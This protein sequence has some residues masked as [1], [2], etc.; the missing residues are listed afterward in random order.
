MV[1]N[2]TN[3]IGDQLALH[4]GIQPV[5]P[6]A[7]VAGYGRAN[8]VDGSDQLGPA[9]PY[10][11]D[12]YQYDNVDAQID[13]W[14]NNPAQHNVDEPIDSE[15]VAWNDPNVVLEGDEAEDLPIMPDLEED[16]D[17]DD[18]PEDELDSQHDGDEQLPAPVPQ[19][20]A[21]QPDGNLAPA[22]VVNTDQAPD[23]GAG[24]DNADGVVVHDA[25]NN[26]AAPG[27]ADDQVALNQEQNQQPA[28]DNHLV[29]DGPAPGTL[30]GLAALLSRYAPWLWT[31]TQAVA[32][33]YV[34]N[35]V[36][37]RCTEFWKNYG[38]WIQAGF[39]MLVVY[40]GYDCYRSWC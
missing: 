32:G 26:A 40:K 21:E 2:D 3:Q 6:V 35:R 18:F 5:V 30:T 11:I 4:S 17:N 33:G 8:W 13:L 25:M 12:L 38:R 37:L 31:G 16:H 24:A 1:H 20:D 36:R 7:P 23:Q 9:D 15:L 19:R 39:G 28:Q 10:K 14:N 22:E 27:P 29:R 34:I